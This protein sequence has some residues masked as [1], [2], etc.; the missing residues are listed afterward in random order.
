SADPDFCR[1]ADWPGACLAAQPGERDR[2]S[3][4]V[5]ERHPRAA[6]A[7]DRREMLRRPD[8]RYGE[9]GHGGGAQEVPVMDPI[10][11]VETGMHTAVI[12]RIGADRECR[13]LATGSEDKT[14]RL[15]SLPEGRL[16]KTLRPPVGSGNDGK[17][18][19]VAVSPDGT[20][21]AAGGW[22]AH[23]DTNSV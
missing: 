9:C 18:Y 3:R 15:W 11:S 16:L 7:A 14:V 1:S 21:V 10:L 23:P 8:R 6:T 13:L 4:P 5:G 17:V 2:P 20:L 12:K 19:A 22:D